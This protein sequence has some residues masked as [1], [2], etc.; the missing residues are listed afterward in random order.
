MLW[1]P[2]MHQKCEHTESSSKSLPFLQAPLSTKARLHVEVDSTLLLELG[3]LS[4][5]AEC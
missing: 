3:P 4:L 1:G 2:G 5:K